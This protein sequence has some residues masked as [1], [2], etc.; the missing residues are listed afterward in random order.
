MSRFLRLLA[1]LGRHVLVGASL[2]LV[3][4]SFLWVSSRPFRSER[5]PQDKTTVTIMHWSGEAGSEEDA[6][7]QNLVEDFEA[8]HPDIRVHRINPGSAG[9]FYTKLQTMMAAGTPPDLFYVGAESLANFAK[10]GLLEPLDGFLE[11]DFMEQ[12]PQALDLDEFYQAPVAGYR[13]DGERTGSGPLYGIPKDFTTI[14]FYYN[15][16]LFAAAELPEPRADWTWDD[17]I[18]AAR[19][20]GTLPGCTG[21]EFVTWPV[22][23]RLYL[24]TEGFDVCTPDFQTVRLQEP[25]VAAV[26]QRLRDWRHEETSTLTSG[27]S[28]VAAG[29]SVFLTG[30]VGMAGPFGRWVVPS[31]RRIQS[32]DWDFAP[33]PRGRVQANS[34]ATVAW[35][36]SRQTEHREEAWALLR[37]LCGK[38]SQARMASTGFAI[39]TIREVAE[40]GVFLDSAAKPKNDRAFLDQ[41]EYARVLTWPTNPKFEERLG[42]RMGQALKTGDLSLKEASDLFAA[43]WRAELRSPL[44]NKKF[45]RMPW[46]FL[47]SL[48]LGLCGFSGAWLW[49]ARSRRKLG[50]LQRREER[51]GFLLVSPW[52]FGF[53]VFLAF[54]I[55]LSLALSFTRWNGISTLEQAQWVGGANYHQLLGFDQR[56]RTSLGVTA[57]YALLA[58]PCGQLVALGAALLLRP[59]SRGMGFFR[60]AWYLPSVLAGV[61]VAVLWRW[62]FDGENGLLNAGLRPIL[63]WVGATPPQWLDE[64]A[65]TWG[66]PA[67]ALMSLWMTGSSMVIY[68]AG[69]KGIPQHLYEAAELDGSGRWRCFRHVTLP[70]LSPVIFFNLIMAIIGSFQV[71]TQAF[72]MTGGEPG[73]LTR[74]YVLYLYNQAFDFYEMGYASALAWLLFLLILAL[75]LFV[76]RGSRRM[77]YYEALS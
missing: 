47:S 54:P 26:L 7:V 72:V 23:V 4:A 52:L 64:D 1:R 37:H 50:F 9:F 68:L 43:E 34:V 14:G 67:F 59:N 16:N 10:S 42:N 11:Q 56:F 55:L 74:F 44:R 69:L 60:S 35:C 57:Y 58:V 62:V 38:R 29:T 45:P 24:M 31:Y 12:H 5:G 39:P 51:A 61:G 3:V 70:M 17:F 2:V 25:E 30:K 28:Q 22:M 6:I 19:E 8:Q 18:H 49:V 73:D 40:S 75:T 41:A 32:F 20:I 48:V 33:L 63:E 27:K 71:F 77:V 15:R 65:G 36:M 46:S 76:M 13:F 21:A 66:P 53:L